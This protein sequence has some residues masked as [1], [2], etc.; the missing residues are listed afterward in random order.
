MAASHEMVAPK[1]E[2]IEQVVHRFTSSQVV[3]VTNKRIIIRCPNKTIS[4]RL[5]SLINN[6]GY[7]IEIQK[8]RVSD[9]MYIQAWL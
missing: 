3:E 5:G 9:A 4:R 2:A 8:G 6:L 1:V 7:P